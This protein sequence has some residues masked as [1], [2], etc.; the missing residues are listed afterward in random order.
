[1]MTTSCDLGSRAEFGARELSSAPLISAACN[2]KRKHRQRCRRATI[3]SIIGG[4]LQGSGKL[5]KERDDEYR[6][7]KREKAAL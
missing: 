6:G 1:M 5:L 4:I 7:G 2:R 3:T